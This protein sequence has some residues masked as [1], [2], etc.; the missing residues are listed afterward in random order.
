MNIKKIVIGHDGRGVDDGWY[1]HKVVIHVDCDGERKEFLYLCNRLIL[2]MNWFLF[3][4]RL[5]ILV[6]IKINL[7]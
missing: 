6:V 2:T 4:L 5:N 3:V 7:V 1:L